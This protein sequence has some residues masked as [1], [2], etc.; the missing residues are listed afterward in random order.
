MML[1]VSQKECTSHAD[2][3]CLAQE[4]VIQALPLDS[5]K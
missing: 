1:Q 4:N 5:R 2:V 3:A